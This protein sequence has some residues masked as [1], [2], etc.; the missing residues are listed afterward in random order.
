MLGYYNN[1]E[2]TAEVL[3]DGWYYTGDLGKIDERGFIYITGRKKNVI[4]TKNGK[5]VYPEELEFYL[6]NIPCVA[7]SM[8]WGKDAEYG[9]DT[10]II[11]SILVNEEEVTDRLGADFTEEELEKL[12]WKEIDKI[13]DGLPFF[14]RVKK[15]IIRKEEFEKTTT[16]KIVRYK[17]K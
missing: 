9:E 17:L 2:A 8:V 10:V 7:E 14:K 12:L 13:N 15:I 16:K 5:N 11:A 6:S 1:P 3:K 4:I